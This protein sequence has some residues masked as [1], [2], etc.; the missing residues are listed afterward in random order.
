MKLMIQLGSPSLLL[1]PRYAIGI[2]KCL[3]LPDSTSDMI[4]SLLVSFLSID[5]ISLRLE[6]QAQRGKFKDGGGNGRRLIG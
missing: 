6:Q 1:S 4:S 5:L 2:R 3:H